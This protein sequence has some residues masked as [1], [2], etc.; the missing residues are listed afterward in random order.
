[1]PKTKVILIHE[2]ITQSWLKDAGSAL[3][4]AAVVA[5][6]SWTGSTTAENLGWIALAFLFFCWV[7]G[8]DKNEKTPQE[9][10]DYLRERYGV[11]G[12]SEFG[13]RLAGG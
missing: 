2:T 1:M 8:R 11:V 6:G 10:A 5:L 13:R 9:A 3:A 7:K 4:C 12:R